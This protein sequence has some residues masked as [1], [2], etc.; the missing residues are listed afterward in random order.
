MAIALLSVAAC[1]TDEETGMPAMLKT[2]FQT[3]MK[4]ILNDVRRA[5]A[6]A[7]TLGGRYLNMSELQGEYFSRSVPDTYELTLSDVTDSSYRAQ[8]KHKA[9]GLTCKLE[10]GTGQGNE[11]PNCD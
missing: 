5:E 2:R 4:T 6:T 11:N 8:V 1:S 9:S 10:V 3:E 7:H